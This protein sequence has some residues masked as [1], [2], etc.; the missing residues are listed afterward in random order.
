MIITAT[1][2]L[3]KSSSIALIVYSL[4]KPTSATLDKLTYKGVIFPYYNPPGVTAI[5][6]HYRKSYRR[7]DC[8]CI[9]ARTLVKMAVVF[10]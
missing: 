9:H 7:A 5:L 8:R 4:I 3:I 2:S 1:K 6:F 10:D